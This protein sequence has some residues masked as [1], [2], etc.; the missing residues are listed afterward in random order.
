MHFIFLSKGRLDATNSHDA[1]DIHGIRFFSTG[2]NNDSKTLEEHLFMTLRTKV[3][4]NRRNLTNSAL[5]LISLVRIISGGG[6]IVHSRR[7]CDEGKHHYHSHNSENSEMVNPFSKL[8][9]NSIVSASVVTTTN[10]G[11]RKKNVINPVL[12]S[13]GRTPRGAALLAEGAS[14]RKI[15]IFH[16]TMKEF[17]IAILWFPEKKTMCWLCSQWRIP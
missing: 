14:G 1:L 17:S 4:R 10:L 11:A 6:K 12:R 2:N 5:K 9:V 16:E 7:A 8:E 15:S 3:R 13:L